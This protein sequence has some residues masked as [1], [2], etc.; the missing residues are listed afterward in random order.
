MKKVLSFL[1]MLALVTGLLIQPAYAI[2]LGTVD[3]YEFEDLLLTD[4]KG[5]YET[6]EL[7]GFSG[8]KGILLKATQAGEFVWFKVN[9]K[10]RALYNIKIGVRKGPDCGNL[11]LTFPDYNHKVGPVQI[12]YSP[13]YKIEEIEIANQY[14]NPWLERDFKMNVVGKD[15]KS[16]GYNLAIDYIVLTAIEEYKAMGAVIPFDKPEP[17]PER[18]DSVYVWDQV[19]QGGTGRS[20]N[21]VFHPK[22]KN[23]AYMGTDMGGAYRWEEDTKSWTPITDFLTT[24]QSTFAGI[25]GIAVD[26]NNPDVV[27]L[28]AGTYA[29]RTEQ[30]IGDVLKSTDRGNT[31]KFTGLNHYFGAN[32]GFRGFGE[33]IAV[34]PAN[35]NI[36]FVATLDDGLYKSTDGAATWQKAKDPTGFVRNEIFSRIIVFDEGTEVNGVTQRIYIGVV[37]SGVYVSEDAGASWSLMPDSP[38]APTRIGIS[39]DDTLVVGTVDKG[40]MKYK[41]GVWSNISPVEG[42]AFRQ[43]AID[44]KNSDYIVTNYHYGPEGS[45]G[46]H[47]YLTTDGGKT[48]KLLNDTMIRNHTVPRVEWGGF[49]ANVSDI[50]IDPFNP[51]RVFMVGWQNFYSTDDI[52]AENTVWTNYVRGVEHGVSAQIVTMPVGARL[53]TSDYDFNGLRHIDVTQYPDE[54]LFP[55]PNSAR[56]SFMESDPNFHVRVARGVG[57]Y[58][59]DN[60]ISWRYFESFPIVDA[61]VIATAVSADVKPDTGLPVIS[62]VPFKSVPYITYDLGKTWIQSKGAPATP[63]NSIWNVETHMV[64]DKVERNIL[65][66]YA[67]N[68]VF[69]SDDYGE[70]FIEVSNLG[71]MGSIKTAPYMAGE[72]WLSAGEKGLYRSPDKGVTFTRV[73]TIDG[74]WKVGF[75]KEEPGR[76]N[77]TIYAWGNKNGSTGIFRSVNMGQDWLQ[78]YNEDTAVKKIFSLQTLE[79]DRQDFGVV[80]Y[81]TSG[82]GVFYG[83]PVGQNPFYKNVNDDIRV[84]LN[85]QTVPFDVSPVLINDRTMVPMR[86]I[87]E[88]SGAKVEWDEATQTVTATRKVSDNYGIDTTVVKLTIGSNKIIINGEENEMDVTPVVKDGRTLVPVRFI[89]QALGAKVIWDEEQSIVRITI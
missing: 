16:S 33:C 42:G 85:N 54:M 81:G 11:Q 20:T 52:F 38:G 88:V 2:R 48:W 44:K 61:N 64:S 17:Q 45:Y 70:N 75:G 3:K 46:Q 53:M 68:K 21:I 12:L 31:W 56:I 73:D 77:P 89:S 7:E 63:I 41:D 14:I 34:D 30:Y 71:F 32:E 47:S 66:Y 39:D 22:E 10:Q 18:A 87:F 58:S 69:R 43:V 26:H 57:V 15:E 40:L 50:A 9:I 24:E 84:I 72:I 49:F 37:G 83:A 5:D 8:G 6:I 80:Y 86:Q 79:G 62:V 55:K 35:S 4:Y 60:G 74:C 28:A 51:K 23:L 13:E 78:I 76:T 29:T 82:R 59:T 19:V 65:Y 25:D 36:I 27:Y 1:L 67:D